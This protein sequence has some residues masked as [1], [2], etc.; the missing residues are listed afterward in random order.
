[1]SLASKLAEER[2]AR[3][4]A[5]RL[6]EQKQAELH[7]ANRKLGRHAKLLS[8][9]IDEQ[10][11]EVETVL[12]A[13]EKVKSDL[14]VAHQRIE[15]AE[16]RLWLS[17]ETIQDGFA[18]WD[19]EGKMIAANRAWLKVFE[20]L[21]EI[22]PG[23]SYVRT[24]QLATEEG[25]IDIGTTAP[26]DWRQ[27]MLRRWQS[28]S[29]EPRVI[30]LWNGQYV[31]LLDQRGHEGDI[32]SLAHNI[33]SSVRYERR[34][35]DA[36]HRAEAANRA[37][38]AFLANMSHEIRTPMN[39]VVGMADL[40]GETS[41]TQDQ[42]LFVD[43]IRSSGE[44]LLV[45]INDV[46]D[47]SKIEAQKLELHPRPFDLERCIHEVVLL[48]QPSARDKDLS[49]LVDY[50]LFTPTSFVGDPGRLRQVLTNLVGNAVKFTA[51]GHILIRVI[52]LPCGESDTT[53]ITL[54][55]ED[56]GIGIAPEKAELVFGEFNQVDSDSSR[57]FEGTGLGL[58][59]SQRLIR[60]M[61]GQIWVDSDLGRGSA[62]G[63]RLGLPLAEAGDSGS[64]GRGPEQMPQLGRVMIVDDSD[65]QVSILEKQLDL[66]GAQTVTCRSGAEALE[67]LDDSIELVLTDHN[68]DGMDGLELA[69]AIRASGSAVPIILFSPAV[70]FA[71]MDP[72]RRHLHAVLQRPTLR[73]D[74]FRVLRT[75][76]G[77]AA[78]GQSPETGAPTAALPPPDGDRPA[79][80]LAAE[81]NRT[82]RL[83]FEKFLAGADID[84]RFVTNGAEAVEA[85][86]DFAPDVIF[87][88]ISMPGMDGKEATRLIRAAEAGTGVHVPIIAMTAHA[89]NGDE[90]RFLALGL[91]AYLAKPLRKADVL[92]RLARYTPSSLRPPFHGPEKSGRE[93]SGPDKSGPDKQG[94]DDTQGPE[95][96][97]DAAAPDLTPDP[98]PAPRARRKA[99]AKPRKA[100]TKAKPKAAPTTQSGSADQHPE[101]DNGPEPAR[102]KR[103][104]P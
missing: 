75:L 15:V 10:R 13:H 83:V 89:L 76:K 14:S 73:D 103:A 58:A 2:R 27:D 98:V 48:L 29:P 54:T 50:D 33:T 47:Y 74:L 82:N 102:P 97:T 12:S 95:Q 63:F 53:D 41:L 4:A 55:V 3:L 88:D 57:Q 87:M 38:S 40:L 68:M 86:A 56:T 45:I 64:D 30:R 32:V 81:D 85:H 17:I 49:L 28:P 7:A 44:A 66:L 92:D 6:L 46:L 11:A 18:F 99:A 67:K 77:G 84:L 39:G 62:F 71:E 60:L 93:K 70:H 25:V 1:M 78:E 101:A 96:T 61:G 19:V 31:K 21:G 23:V 72:A 22:V 65:L 26:Q 69:E 43:T 100:A 59:I 79:R 9:R 34:L 90:E 24:L 5:E 42:R 94:P 36:R 35:R 104:R 16:K 91:D 37:K 8:E 20:D 80:V 51:R 52:G